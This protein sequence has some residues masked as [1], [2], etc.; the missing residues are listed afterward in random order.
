[1]VCIS[2]GC[3]AKHAGATRLNRIPC[4]HDLLRERLHF[5]LPRCENIQNHR[6][7]V[8]IYVWLLERFVPQL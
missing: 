7:V 8:G 2:G 6:Q 5:L 1:M 3:K 4:V